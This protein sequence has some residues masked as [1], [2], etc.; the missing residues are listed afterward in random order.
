MPHVRLNIASGECTRGNLCLAGHGAQPMSSRTR[1]ATFA[2]QSVFSR[3]CDATHSHPPVAKPS[4]GDY[5]RV[6]PHRQLNMGCAARQA[7]HGLRRI[8]Y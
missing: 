2:A 4:I 7:K 5:T 1:L 3:W 8:G 6:V